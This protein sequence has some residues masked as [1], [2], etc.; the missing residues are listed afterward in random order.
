MK[1]LKLRF[2][3]ATNS[4][5]SHSIVIWKDGPLPKDED[6]CSPEFGWD[7][8][9]LASKEAKAK[10]LGVV[11]MT[12]GIGPEVDGYIDHNSNWYMPK[13]AFTGEPCKEGLEALLKF[14]EEN[15]DC[16]ILGGND[17]SEGHPLKGDAI[18]FTPASLVRDWGNVVMRKD[19]KGFWTILRSSIYGPVVKA[20]FGE[21]ATKATTPEL[22]DIKI[23]DF[24]AKGCAFCYQG[25]TTKGAR[26]SKETLAKAVDTLSALGVMEVAIGGGEP[27]THPNLEFFLQELRSCRITPNV[28][29][30]DYAWAKKQKLVPAGNLGISIG[31][32]FKDFISCATHHIVM[33]TLSREEFR[34]LLTKGKGKSFLLL[35][36]KA[37]KGAFNFQPFSWWMQEVWTLQQSINWWGSIG[38]DTPLAAMFEKELKGANIDTRLYET[39]EGKFSCYWDLVEG[40]IAPSSYNGEPVA[41]TSFDANEFTEKFAKW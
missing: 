13:D 19:L 23:T 15:D 16:I 30:M 8:F 14:I 3:P 31:P 5:S 28:T 40:K 7:D 22:V 33:G 17:N 9:T 6:Y 2:G 39:E 11:R 21:E 38:I 41:F 24:C 10:Y 26:A 25:S 34:E 20:R 4:S 12:L 1:L 35:A 29:T 18:E 36:P 27:S 37:P 32:G